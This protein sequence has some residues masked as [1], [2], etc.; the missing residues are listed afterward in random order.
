MKRI[1]KFLT[2]LLLAPLPALH[3]AD[4]PVPAAPQ[5]LM[6]KAESFRHYVEDFNRNDNEL[7]A[8]HVS[9]AAAWEFLQTKIPLLD[10]PDK[11]L[12]IGISF[13]RTYGGGRLH[14]RGALN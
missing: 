4:A 7:Y 2:I 11:E 1:I 14:C 9:N 12:L 8:Q 5:A 13:L 6:L 10:C 3:A